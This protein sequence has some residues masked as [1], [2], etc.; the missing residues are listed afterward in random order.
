MMSSSYRDGTIIHARILFWSMLH[1][2]ICTVVFG[3][4][5]W[6]LTQ[7]VKNHV[8]ESII[9][10]EYTLSVRAHRSAGLVSGTNVTSCYSNVLDQ[11]I[12]VIKEWLPL[13]PVELIFD[14]DECS[15]SD[16]EE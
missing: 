6:K 13:E 1:H 15:Y 11:Y 5:R 12:P 4:L 8:N 3:T 10:T 14:I 9:G 7:H 2:E 16:W